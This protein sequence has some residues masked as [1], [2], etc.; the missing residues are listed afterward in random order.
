MRE[1]VWRV[2]SKWG[3]GEGGD[4]GKGGEEGR[5]RGEVLGCEGVKMLVGSGRANTGVRATTSTVSSLTK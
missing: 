2:V 4:G 5:R 1:C 3:V